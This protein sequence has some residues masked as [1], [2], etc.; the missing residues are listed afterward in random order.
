MKRRRI[1]KLFY[2]LHILSQ[3]ERSYLRE[4]ISDLQPL[5]R[6][7]LHYLL[8][9]TDLESYFFWEGEWMRVQRIANPNTLR[10]IRKI[11]FEW[12]L[13]TMKDYFNVSSQE[14]KQIDLNW[15]AFALG[16][17]THGD[18]IFNPCGLDWQDFFPWFGTPI[19]FRLEQAFLQGHL[20]PYS[21]FYKNPS[22]EKLKQL[23]DIMQ[24][25]VLVE[26]VLTHLLR[27]L[28]PSLYVRH[29]IELTSELQKCLQEFKTDFHTLL[30]NADELY[31][32]E[33]IIIY[34]QFVFTL[35]H[36]QWEWEAKK[37][38]THLLQWVRLLYSHFGYHRAL[39]GS[40][41]FTLA[42]LLCW[43]RF[44]PSI[45][46]KDVIEELLNMS[47][48]ILE[49]HLYQP[50]LTSIR[51][52]GFMGL[53]THSAFLSVLKGDLGMV[54]KMLKRLEWFTTYEGLPYYFLFPYII[55][56]FWEAFLQRNYSRAKVWVERLW[57]SSYIKGEGGRVASYLMQFI[58]AWEL[59]DRQ[60]TY[61]IAQQFYMW[62][63]RNKVA[64]PIARIV[65]S[66]AKK[67]FSYLTQEFWHKKLLELKEA[68]VA[69]PL[70]STIEY[71]FP[72][73]VWIRSKMEQLPF[74][75]VFWNRPPLI[76][77]K[78]KQQLAKE[79]VIDWELSFDYLK[80]L[81]NLIVVMEKRLNNKE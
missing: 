5:A 60:W 29:P 71:Q 38:I 13:N 72:L 21:K 42:Y 35:F 74:S 33:V 14:R 53:C 25:A 64:R 22:R 81:R 50:R 40:C 80:P 15:V 56:R 58:V 67:G 49:G 26:I 39:D 7:Y 8:K 57:D 11:T 43:A 4:R 73:S 30:K 18:R 27:Q 62:S 2:L 10:W 79:K 37:V 32:T 12:V 20:P 65:R 36:T 66:I 34:Q 1:P 75:T 68:Y 45:L 52:I 24:R 46:P 51:V 41:I 70:L 77:L 63:Y 59:G 69:S 47:D 19:C 78:E 44:S 76:P 6:K 16:V 28:V 61:A 55:A 23:V 3:W 31:N 17:R 9:A 48:Q 54:R